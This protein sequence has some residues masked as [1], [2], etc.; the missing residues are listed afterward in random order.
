MKTNLEKFNRL[1]VDCLSVGCLS[2]SA[3]RPCLSAQEFIN[4]SFFFC[5]QSLADS[6][7]N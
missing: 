3:D 7:V 6:S 5:S 4:V 1:Q 2:E